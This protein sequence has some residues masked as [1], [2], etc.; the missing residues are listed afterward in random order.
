VALKLHR[1]RSEKNDPAWHHVGRHNDK[2]IAWTDEDER[3][4]AWLA[5]VPRLGRVKVAPL[6]NPDHRQYLAALERKNRRFRQKDGS[7][8]TEVQ[9][10]I[11]YE[12]AARHVLLDWEEIELED[13]TG[14]AYTPAKGMRALQE[15]NE[16][17]FVV[18]NAAAELARSRKEATEE[19]AAALGNGSGGKSNG[20]D[21]PTTRSTARRDSQE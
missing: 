4:S 11:N 16:F 5:K 19:D 2:L 21:S 1:D 18:V 12:A 20:A 17:E 6:M 10:A 9:D 7:L 3:D 8:P 13:G 15:S 14:G